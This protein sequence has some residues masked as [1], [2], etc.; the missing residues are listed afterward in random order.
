MAVSKVA[1]YCYITRN[2]R[3]FGIGTVLLNNGTE[4]TGYASGK[5]QRDLETG[6][7]AI[8]LLTTRQPRN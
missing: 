7:I 4:H 1:T 5:P 8:E 3:C 6:K 2:N